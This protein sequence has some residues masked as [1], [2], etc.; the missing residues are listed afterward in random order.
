[1]REL[2]VDARMINAS[3]IGTYLKN[4]LPYMFE[5]FKKQDNVRIT[6]LYNSEDKE[7]IQKYSAKGTDIKLEAVDK[8]IY[9]ISEQLYFL[10]KKYSKNTVFWSPH[11]NIPYFYNGDLIV[12]VH[13]VYH[14]DDPL[15]TLSKAEKAYAKIFF[16]RIRKKAKKVITIS[17]FSK[18]RLLEQAKIKQ[19][20]EV[21]YNGVSDVWRQYETFE[22]KGFKYFIYVGNVKP[23]KNLQ[24]LLAAFTELK[25]PDYKLVIVGKKEGFINGDQET[26]SRIDN[27]NIIFT[28]R[29]S[30]E[31]LMSYVKSAEALIFPSLYEGFGLPPIEAMAMGCPTIV[32]NAASI[33]EVSGDAS[34]YF[35]PLNKEDLKQQML[36]LI[37]DDKLRAELVKKGLAHAEKFKWKDAAKSTI[38]I[39]EEVVLR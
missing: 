32:S 24:V 25:L 37:N 16:T 20:V 21:I 33:P 38:K 1:M 7:T 30:D 12:T 27:E 23:H 14:L 4:I 31:E 13:D 29:V 15:G 9:S 2:I 34:L 19:N 26:S 36:T 22:A 3:G 11:Y 28:G 10:K 39:I 17:N 18:D 35:D 5:R 6:L 8:G